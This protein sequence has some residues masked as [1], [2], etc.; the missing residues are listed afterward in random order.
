MA[1]P[2]LSFVAL[3]R[4]HFPLVVGWLARPH[5]AAWWHQPQGAEAFEA[6]YGPCVDGD[7]PTR[8]FLGLL[9][10]EP[11]AFVQIYRVDDEPTYKNAVGVE[12]AAGLDLFLADAERC[13]Q[14]L[15]TRVIT[16][17]VELLWD[18]YPEVAR[19][20]ASP[21]VH[22]ARSIRAFEKSGF[23]AKGAVSVPDEVDQ[24]MVM[25]RE[26]PTP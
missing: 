3:A 7:D 4:A 2:E 10:S 17:A 18:A 22:N 25:V 8:A 14:G 1:G 23:T 19:A 21:S 12:R 26:R 9:G 16:A 20:V 5:V 11:V 24:E 13:D 6:E 15:G